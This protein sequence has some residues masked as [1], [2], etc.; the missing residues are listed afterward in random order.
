LGGTGEKI[1]GCG[2]KLGV[3][4][5]EGKRGKKKCREDGGGGHGSWGGGREKGDLV[6]GGM[7]TQKVPREYVKYY[8]A[9]TS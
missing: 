7:E 3:K 4:G 9:S 8:E 1:L 2:R 6:R 5:R